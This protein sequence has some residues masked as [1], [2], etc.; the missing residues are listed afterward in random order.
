MPEEDEIIHY[1]RFKRGLRAK[2]A[3]ACGIR[4]AAVYQW[5]RVPPRHAHT[6][7]QLLGVEVENVR[8]DIFIAP[9]ELFWPSAPALHLR[10]RA[11]GRVNRINC[12]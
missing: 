4:R 3:R 11:L 2:V 5:N 6:V 8:P 7:A 12:N 9:G 10:T 1:L